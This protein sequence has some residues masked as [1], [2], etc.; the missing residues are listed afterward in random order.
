MKFLILLL[1]LMLSSCGM[2]S[3]SGS[4]LPS[5]LKT[6]EVPLF[7]NRALTQGAAEDLTDELTKAVARE[8][9]KLVAT[10]GDATLKGAVT[11]YR[12]HTYDYSGGRDNLNVKNY[13]VDIIASVEFIDNIKKKNIYKGTVTAKGV[14]D[15]NSETE[16]D[17]RKRA[18]KA[19]SEKIMS[20]S[21]QG[22]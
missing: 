11:G 2:Y 20:N 18:I 22:W 13:A 15:F 7:E 5:Y 8:N 4:S 14:Y 16:E 12:N 21:L 6:I 19:L 1:T 17:G 3:F 9:L 10:K